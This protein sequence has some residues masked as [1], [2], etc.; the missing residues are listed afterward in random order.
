[1]ESRL[2]FEAE[3]FEDYTEFDEWEDAGAWASRGWEGEVNRRSPEYVRRVQRALNRLLGLKLVSDGVWGTRTRNAVI[4][5]QKRRGLKA[6]GVL[7][8]QTERAL[9]ATEESQRPGTEGGRARAD[10]GKGVA[11]KCQAAVP[12]LER[13]ANSLRFLNN[14]LSKT[15]P[16]QT[17]L[18]L[19]KELVRLDAEAIIASLAAYI[20]AGCCE[21]SLKALEAEVSALPWPADP[22]VRAPRD[23]LLDAIRKAQETARKDFEHC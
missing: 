3:P 21:P 22:D 15:P 9:F 8:S 12:D 11:P 17:R 16:S 14:E 23:K 1:M 7:D 2:I 5:F 13:L 10:A 20:T 4:A 18:R 19:L 6:S